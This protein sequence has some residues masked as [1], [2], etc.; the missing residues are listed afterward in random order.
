MK[1]A[2]ALAT[3]A[4]IVIAVVC[5]ASADRPA[6]VELARLTPENWEEFAP[7]GKE[8]D[9]I[10]GDYVLRN[11]HLTAVIAQPLESRHA[12]MSV[13]QIAGALID[14][15]TREGASDQLGAYY[16][17]QRQFAYRQ[18]KALD[19][20][21]NPVDLQQQT[22]AAG[23]AGAIVVSAAAGEGRPAV[24]VTYSLAAG[25]RFIT[26]TSEFRNPSDKPL[27]IPLVDDLRIDGGKEDL[28]KAANGIA[29][30]FW[31]HD[32][33][34]K[35]AYGI[36]ATERQIQMN[37]DARTSTLKY[38]DGENKENVVLPPGGSFRLTR[39]I[40]PGANLL[41]VK[42]VAGSLRG[43]E[44][45]P[46]QIVVLGEGQPVADA[47]V[48]VFDGDEL[49]GTGRT[50]EKGRLVT[51]LPI[52][53]YRVGVTALGVPL[54]PDVQRPRFR[55][56]QGKSE[57]KLELPYRPGT[58]AATITDA[59]GQPIPCKVEFIAKEGTP[60][61]N[62][63][64]DSADFAVRNLRYAPL[65]AFEQQL[66]AGQYRV[67]ISHGPEYDAVF[68]ELTVPS[69]KT[70]P[71]N[72][73]LVRSVN[74]KGWISSDFHS[75]SSPS[76]DNTGS[77]LGRVL[78][79]V[80]E[81]IEFAP[82]T[83]HNRIDTYEPHIERLRIEKFL[84]TTSGVELTGSPL[85]LNHQNA[86]P[87]IRK[88]Y[89]QDGGAP[90]P[91]SDPAT[92][93]ERLALW[94]NRSDKLV[95]VN[96]PDMGWMFYDKDGDREPDAGLDRMFAHIEV[97][98]IHP[99]QNAL[100]V[101][102][103][104][105]PRENV[106]NRVFHWLQLLNQ[107]FRI[108]GVVNTDSH[109]NFHGSGWLRNWVQSPTDEPAKID[110][111]DVVHAAEQGRVIVSNGPFLEVAVRE[112]GVGT[113]VTAGQDLRSATGK[114][115]VH[116]R[117][118]CAN[119]FDIDRVFVLVNGRMDPAHNFTRRTHA[120]KFRTEGALKFDERI[121]L[122]LP[123]DAHLV[124]VAGGEN[125]EL[126]PVVGPVMAKVQPAALSNPIFVDVDGG[127]FKSNKDTLGHPLPVK[128]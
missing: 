60:Q 102:P 79:L 100:L 23:K 82:C 107:G 44:S 9:A 113:P 5:G 64:P 17:G 112:E 42:A 52:G 58:V 2:A 22:T 72:A 89:Q 97:I 30:L 1:F 24:D 20:A 29:S 69:G 35:Q 105:G 54:T 103:Y 51:R 39:R 59:E 18:W 76:G 108:P 66:P 36:D 68:T 110:P 81:H 47:E 117:V 99:V 83:E 119:W 109:Y 88:P 46:T 63:G 48:S 50:D 34:W 65:G 127:G 41:D 94:D 45:Q 53:D 31:A 101:G 87:L 111:M 6:D 106:N 128:R 56:D 71:L 15:T 40:F 126:G 115:E 37:S 32:K 93:I 25:D 73:Q 85:P 16:P 92:Q 43:Q 84:A 19:A 95:Q 4:I 91:D 78:N 38:L 8:V 13:R 124:V 7:L 125:L 90:L 11:E 96:H 98:E 114:V 121:T 104:E 116:I 118:Q 61:P 49:R 57:L 77:Q 70:V 74:T 14:L 123:G 3:A 75:H 33:F 120:D 67:I 12:N 62:F 26:V 28:D 10:A 21:G 122:Q 86:F 55:V 80:A 27:T